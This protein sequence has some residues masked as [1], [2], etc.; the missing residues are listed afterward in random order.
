MLIGLSLVGD[1]RQPP[2]PSTPAFIPLL[3]Y[4]A[5]C[6]LCVSH[7]IDMTTLQIVVEEMFISVKS[8]L[9]TKKGIK[10]N[11][12]SAFLHIRIQL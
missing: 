9:S 2:S 3:S 5:E 8:V 1:W 7:S 4:A 12:E 6:T 10:T 11:F